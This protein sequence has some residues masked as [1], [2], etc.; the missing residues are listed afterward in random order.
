M[1]APAV[2][3]RLASVLIAGVVATTVVSWIALGDPAFALGPLAL[4]LLVWM[5]LEAPLHRIALVVFFL[6]I[7]ADNPKEHPFEDKWVSP[8]QPLGVFLYENLNNLT[9]VQALR[10]SGMDL[11]LAALVIVTAVRERRRDAVAPPPV[12][13]TF[14][15]AAW[16]AVL[17]LEAW[18]LVRG[19]DFKAS[20][21]QARPL[22]WAPL[23]VYVF[24]AALRGPADHAALG[25]AVVVAA[26]IKAAFGVYYYVAI[27]RPLGH[28]PPTAT[29]HSDTV[30]FVTAAVIAAAH[31]L[32]RRTIVAA[33]WAL[34]IA[35]VVGAGIVVNGRRLAY[36]SLAG[37]IAVLRFVLPPDGLRR[38]F[39]RLLL[40][41]TPLSAIYLAIGWRSQSRFFG[42]AREVASLFA[43]DDTSSQMRDI[44]N[45][46][47][48][49]T[50][51]QQLFLGSGFGHEY[52]E[53]TH[54][55]GIDEIFSLYRYIGHNSILWLQATGGVVGFTAFWMLLAVLA[56]FAAR[57]FRFATAPVDRA[58]A[59]SALSVVTIFGI[60]AHGDMGL[61][62][63]MAIFLFAM[64]LAVAA[65]LAVASGAFPSAPRSERT[66]IHPVPGDHL[67]GEPCSLS[68]SCS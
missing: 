65:K 16:L 2:S 32:E 60:Q 48:I 30:L 53:L 5:L 66:P 13:H 47:L 54:P 22:F 21:W 1:S 67:G 64:S 61:N 63:W 49:L 26:M 27:C 37:A 46:N 68:T 56:Y 20:L 31:W 29:T 59:L 8:L 35:A 51:K 6:A 39:D 24:A 33:L 11:L 7:L 57:S 42:P 4:T 3:H 41:A 40:A 43:P 58:A 18:G 44:E 12:L 38:S 50:W 17:W 28:V 9:G 34:G 55:F 19:G 15:A 62:S 52:Q 10:F 36:I 14:L 23:I 25:K 45:Y